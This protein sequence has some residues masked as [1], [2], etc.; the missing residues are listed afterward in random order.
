[1]MITRA[2]QH[3][4]MKGLPEKWMHAKDE[5]YDRLRGPAKDLTILASAFSAKEQSGSGEDEPLLIVRDYGK[6]RVFHT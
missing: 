6:G 1:L 5:L 3:P 4:I 2:P